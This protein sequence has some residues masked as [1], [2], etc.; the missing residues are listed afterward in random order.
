MIFRDSLTNFISSFVYPFSRNTSTCGN[1]LN[2]IRCCST[3][4]LIAFSPR[5]NFAVCS[6]SSAIAFAP[7]PLAA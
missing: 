6:S 2:A 4:A 3:S 1:K 5:N 7:A